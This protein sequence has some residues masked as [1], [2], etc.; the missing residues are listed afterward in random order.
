M[1]QPSSRHQAGMVREPW[2]DFNPGFGGGASATEGDFGARSYSSTYRMLT[3]G[4]APNDQGRPNGRLHAQSGRGRPRAGGAVKLDRSPLALCTAC[5]DGFA[6]MSDADM[7]QGIIPPL[8]TPLSGPDALDLPGLERLVEHVLAGG[9][10]GLFILGTTGEAPGL[11]YRLRGELIRRV[12]SQVNG[13]VPVLVGITDTAFAES[14]N[15]ARVAAEAG[16]SALVLS[17]PYYFPA[18][19]TELVEYVTGL[20]PELPLP[21][22][23]YNIPSLTKVEFEIETLRRLSGFE[24]IIGVKDSGGDL[25][26]YRELLGLSR[27][28]PDWRYMIGPEHL[29]IESVKAGGHGGVNGGANVFP[30]LFVGA[31]EAAKSGD[32]ARMKE[33]Q[34]RIDSLQR[35]YAIGKYA[36]RFIKATKSALSLRGICDDRMAQPFNHFEAP[37]RARVAQILKEFENDELVR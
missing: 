36:S 31:Y 9:V 33:L 25:G 26:Y 11:G 34:A 17:T 28:R 22:V 27:E 4:R 3:S 13:R 29:L 35:I 15:V 2:F 1:E 19:Q 18:G 23:L 32:E 8:V 14:L 6:L 30:K 21:L 5:K 37:E 24:N 10:S 16:A 7:L 12:C 20:V